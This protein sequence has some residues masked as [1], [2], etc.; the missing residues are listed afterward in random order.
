MRDNTPR[1][2]TYGI[3]IRTISSGAYRFF[4]MTQD[5][6]D[7]CYLMAA[8][9]EPPL[10]EH[11]HDPKKPSTLVQ[12]V[13]TKD[14]LYKLPLSELKMKTLLHHLMHDLGY[15]QQDSYFPSMCMPAEIMERI[16]SH[17]TF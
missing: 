11:T 7:H 9:S 4:N 2:N 15:K 8:K 13:D 1:R 6:W 14:K 17:C 10:R 16:L 3:E 5:E 12:F